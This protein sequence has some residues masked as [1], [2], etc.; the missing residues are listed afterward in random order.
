MSS[1]PLGNAKPSLRPSSWLGARRIDLLLR[2]ITAAYMQR[3][4]IT[5]RAYL[6]PQNLA[7]GRLVVTIVPGTVEILF[8]YT[9]P[10]A[11]IARS[12]LPESGRRRAAF[13]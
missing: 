5:T 9:E 3:G 11:G 10:L 7:A 8:A 12:A 4:C 2:R 1:Y 6:A 13:T